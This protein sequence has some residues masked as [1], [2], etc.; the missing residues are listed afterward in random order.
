M[1]K[2]NRLLAC[3]AAVLAIAAC[4]GNDGAT[5]P[6]GP[7]G[8]PGPPG[9][10]G[11]PAPGPVGSATGDLTG[12]VTAITIDSAAGQRVTVTF[13]L[14]D[15]NG[16][17]VAGAQDKNFEFQL[18]KL[19][20]ANTQRP[21][22]WQSYINRSDQEGAGAKVLAGGAERGKPAAVD[23]QPGVYRYTFCTPLASVAS[24]IY[25]GSGTEPQGA[26]SATA[27][28]N[29]GVISGSPAWD[30]VQPT[31]DLTY[32]ASASTRLAI[33]GRDGAIVNVVQDFVP[34]SLP[35]LPAA[36]SQQ[37]VTNESCGACHAEDSAKRG[38]LLFGTKGSGHLGRRYMVEVCSACHNPNSFASAA[39]TAAKWETIDLQKMMHE[40]HG[41]HDY[42]QN[43]PFGGVSN[44]G[45]GFPEVKG[46]INCRTCHDNQNPKILPQQ[47]ANRAA[48][49]KNA[50]M[51]NISVQACGSCH[52]GTIASSVD[53][54]NHPLPGISQPGNARCAD[55]HGQDTN[56]ISKVNVTHATPYP[57]FNNPEIKQGAKKVEYQI[58]S[59]TIDSTTRLPTVRFRVLVD[60]A[61]LNLKSLPAGTSLGGVNFKLAWSAPLP[62]PANPSHGTAIAQPL[63]WNNLGGGARQY[64]N[65][66][67]S[68]GTNFRAFDQPVGPTLASIVTTLTGPDADG[69]FTTVAGL[70]SSA[71]VAFPASTTLRAVA[72]E[73]YLTFSTTV[74]GVTTSMN[75]AGNAAMKGE[76]GASTLR[77]AIV[78]IDACN[79][80]HE[81]IGFH[82]NAGRMNSPEYCATCHNPEVSS[83]NVFSGTATFPLA[84]GG[85]TFFYSQK[86]N[87]FKDLIHSIHAGAQ[88][89]AQNPADPFNFIRGNPLASGGSGPM[90]FEN[91]VYPAQV[92]DCKTCHLAGTYKVPSNPRL[93]W[94]VIDAQ[95]ALGASATLFNPALS[96]REGAVSAA[97]SS[98]HNSVSAQAHMVSNTAVGLGEACASCHGPG[99]AFESHKK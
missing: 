24:F 75:V 78:D 22:F 3:V 44:I 48:A 50:W 30:A 32:S 53:Y 18:A 54:N 57:T 58:A 31:L 87:N 47:P 65:N 42:P 61:A 7:S 20:P 10:P 37:V 82:S 13:S 15:A 27:V 8:P 55:C 38:K 77:R 29:S 6:Q 79:T 71:P 70:S 45:T 41:T 12:R 40:Y 1:R 28:A 94:S 93:A 2:L 84:P 9:A 91:V 33:I 19:M 5:G 89:K 74:N 56:S 66:T 96:K 35:T 95:P 99:A 88:R 51:T 81:R 49:D 52:N 62:A 26:C 72:I 36:R 92:A 39:S 23:G 60:G 21:A 86:S 67:T 16:L 46:V 43:A 98:C 97:C 80:C 17:P 90:V 59:M 69:Y 73:S 76:D 25:Y 83:S 11:A 4:G 63:D 34:A 85:G 64:W 68:L 14:A